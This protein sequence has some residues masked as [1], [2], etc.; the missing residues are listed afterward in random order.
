MDCFIHIPKC[1]GRSIKEFT[2][3][4][5]GIT[6]LPHGYSYDLGINHNP[7]GW[8]DIWGNI[9]KKRFNPLDYN[10]IYTIVRNPFDLL[11]SYYFH[12]HL[13]SKKI[14]GWANCNL[15]HNFKSWREFLN[16]YTNPYLPWHLHPMKISLFSMGY[17]INGNWIPS[18]TFY[19]ENLNELQEYFNIKLPQVNKTQNKK[20]N[21]RLYYTPQDVEKLNKI[22]EK[23][24]KKFNYS[25]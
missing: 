1:A 2:S 24:L 8:K 3:I 5:E 15:A 16:T 14:D 4:Q 13:E 21:Y 20:F 7:P 25:F 10:L 11:V 12:T 17:D 22:W 18:K 9:Y 23:D 19:Y 6:K